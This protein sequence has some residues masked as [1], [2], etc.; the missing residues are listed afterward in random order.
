MFPQPPEMQESHP[1]RWHSLCFLTSRLT[2]N[3]LSWFLLW[4]QRGLHFQPIFFAQWTQN[5]QPWPPVGLTNAFRCRWKRWRSFAETRMYWWVSG[6]NCCLTKPRCFLGLKTHSDFQT[7]ILS[8]SVALFL[9]SEYHHQLSP[10]LL[11]PLLSS[12]LSCIYY[13]VFMGWIHLPGLLW[14]SRLGSMMT[15]V[16]FLTVLE[17]R[18]L[19]SRYQQSWSLLRSLSW[20]CRWPS[21]PCVF[22]AS[23]LSGCQ[24]P[25]LLFFQCCQPYWI[26]AR[27]SPVVRTVT[28][29]FERTQ[30]SL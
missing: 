25:H 14:E 8:L 15:E 6:K 29:K 3:G 19:G 22:A 17:A 7:F 18:T 24:C 11:L 13:S 20:A 27:P 21:L 16:Y 30:F 12:L 23:A 9:P 10:L 2:G 1:D 28:H 5:G 4:G 26:R